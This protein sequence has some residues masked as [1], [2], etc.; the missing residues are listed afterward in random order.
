VTGLSFA[1]CAAPRGSLAVRSHLWCQSPRGVVGGWLN[2]IR[3]GSVVSKG[4]GARLR[5]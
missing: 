1:H 5:E 2:S 4:S 3:S